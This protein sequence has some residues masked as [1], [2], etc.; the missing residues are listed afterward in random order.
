MN[1]EGMLMNRQFPI[2]ARVCIRTYGTGRCNPEYAGFLG[3]KGVVA[4][5][6]Q[7]GVSVAWDNGSMSSHMPSGNDLRYV[8]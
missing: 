5:N 1:S 7:S 2:D 4:Y 3:M 8:K 6:D